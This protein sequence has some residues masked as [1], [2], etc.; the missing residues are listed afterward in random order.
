MLPQELP[1]VSPAT[2][3]KTFELTIQMIAA[4]SSQGVSERGLAP[5]AARSVTAWSIDC[6]FTLWSTKGHCRAAFEH[7]EEV[8][9]T[10]ALSILRVAL[11]CSTVYRT[12]S[13]SVCQAQTAICHVLLSC[14]QRFTQIM[15]KE[16]SIELQ[17]EICWTTIT[18]LRSQDIWP[19][20]QQECLDALALLTECSPDHE[21]AL[22][23]FSKDFQRTLLLVLGTGGDEPLE[24]GLNALDFDDQDLGDAASKLPQALGRATTLGRPSKRPRLQTNEETAQA[25]SSM[26]IPLL[27]SKSV[28]AI[29]ESP[30]PSGKSLQDFVLDRFPAL[31]KAKQCELLIMLGRSACSPK[32][33]W[34]FPCA[35][36]DTRA[37]P[38]GVANIVE[39]ET[40]TGLYSFFLELVR[41]SQTQKSPP[42]RVAA[43]IA[44]KHLLA[45]TTMQEYLDLKSSALGQWCLQCLRSSVR[46]LRLAAM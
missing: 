23:I 44:L 31:G 27:L 9:F 36:C 35:L 19:S 13:D 7:C 14:M 17:K 39:E 43:M 16:L 8:C 25:E 11:E 10:L 21:N 20:G 22:R 29:L 6:L 33:S 42:P 41:L 3:T 30:I 1:A 32:H 38:N 2:L 24:L 34:T 18:I 37:K 5:R 28:A 40:S 12:G 45:H 26:E 46:E 4:I 15:K